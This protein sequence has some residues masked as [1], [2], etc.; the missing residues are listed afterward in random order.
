[1]GLIKINTKDG[2]S[3]YTKTKKAKINE[4]ALDITLLAM[5]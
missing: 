3:L 1:M 4:K 5:L 2:L